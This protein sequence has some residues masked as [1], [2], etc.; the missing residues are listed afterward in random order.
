MTDDADN[1]AVDGTERGTDAWLRATT[2]PAGQLATAVLGAACLGVAGFAAV[3]SWGALAGSH[4]TYSVLLVVLWVIGL[5][6]LVAAMLVSRRGGKRSPWWWVAA[7]PVVVLLI[8][9]VLLRPLP[10]HERAIGIVEVSSESGLLG[11]S[12]GI[13]VE[14]TPN[15]LL[16]A[17]VETAEVP[18]GTGLVFYP[19]ARVDP[20]A[21]VTLLAPVVQAGHPVVVVKPPLGFALL[22]VDAARRAVEDYEAWVDTEIEPERWAVGGHSVG[23]VAAS[24]FVLDSAESHAGRGTGT[25]V[26]GLVLWASYP[27]GSLAETE[28]A[29]LAIS[30]TRDALTTPEEI[31]ESRDLLPPDTEF[32]VVDGANHAQFGDYGDQRGDGEAAISDEAA[33]TRIVEATIGFLDRL[34]RL[35]RLD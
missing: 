27:A 34:D 9:V 32:V 10:A 15:H 16:L 14:T 28:L 8:V 22:D 4:P 24:D 35:D 19:G 3:T 1:R 23:G 7:L 31:D 30:G 11:L 17:P 25:E 13:R 20:R 26:V 33:R 12:G 6:L 21:Y 18:V 5:G 29:V 2:V